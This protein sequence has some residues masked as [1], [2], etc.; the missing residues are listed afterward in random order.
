MHKKW[1]KDNI[2]S[3]IE[4]FAIATGHKITA[5]TKLIDNG[6]PSTELSRWM[7]SVKGGH[8]RVQHGHDFVA[9]VGEVHEKFGA[10]GVMKY[11]SETYARCND[12]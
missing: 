1:L 3:I 9:N 4:N 12:S 11:P 6:L 2:V 5:Y 7:D 10:E 8:H